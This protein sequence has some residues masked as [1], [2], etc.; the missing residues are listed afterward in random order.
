MF[1]PG[2]TTKEA[3]LRDLHHRVMTPEI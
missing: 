3:G 2:F 1:V